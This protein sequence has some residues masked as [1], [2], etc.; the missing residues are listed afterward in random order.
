MGIPSLSYKEILR[1][2]KKDGWVVVRQKGSHIRLH[3][4]LRDKLLKLTLPAHD[5]VRKNTLRWIL[6]QGEISLERLLELLGR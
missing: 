3:K 2:L 6:Q 4:R 5:P 1:A